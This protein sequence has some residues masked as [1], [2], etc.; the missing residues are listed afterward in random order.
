MRTSCA[1]F[2]A[3]RRF[4]GCSATASRSIKRW[5]GLHSNMTLEMS[6][7]SRG[8]RIG[9]PL[10]PS[11]SC[12]TMWATKAL[13]KVSFPD[14]KSPSNGTLQLVYWQRP[15]VS[16]ALGAFSVRLSQPRSPPSL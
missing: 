15:L 16:K 12:A 14:I 3:A 5:W 4:S 6:S 11:G 7:I 9:L 2:I 1:N 13:F 10:G 8:D